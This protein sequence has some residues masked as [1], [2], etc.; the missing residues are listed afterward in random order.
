MAGC[1]WPDLPWAMTTSIAVDRCPPAMRPVTPPRSRSA[2]APTRV[3]EA[4][5]DRP[6]RPLALSPSRASDFKTCPLLYRFRAVDRLPSR[7]AR[8]PPAAPWCTACSSRCSAA[9]PTERTPDLT[10]A[11]VGA[12]L[13]ADGRGASRTARPAAGGGSGRLA[14]VGAGPGPDVLHPGGSAPVHP[15]GLRVRGRD[16]G[17]RTRCRCAASST[18]WT[19]RRPGS[20]GSSTTRPAAR[21]IRTSRPGRCTS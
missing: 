16:R 19:W 8:R 15:G 7:P 18:G 11:Q 9:R 1:R 20:C 10:A 21:R 13:G 12:A 6:R 2:A 14:A 4:R 3:D 17:G 5:A